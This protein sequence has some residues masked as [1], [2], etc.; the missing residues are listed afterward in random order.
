MIEDSIN[1]K[2]GNDQSGPDAKKAK[3]GPLNR[4]PVSGIKE[5]D[6]GI[7]EFIYQH[8]DKRITG[9]L[10]Q[11]YTDFQVN[12]IDP[13]G[14]VL[15][16]QDLGFKPKEEVKVKEK[17]PEVEKPDDSQ[18][19]FQ[20][21]DENK[22]K[23]VELI[24][25]EDTEKLVAML[26]SHNTMETTMCFPDKAKRSQIH[27]LIRAAFQGRFETATSNDDKIRIGINSFRRTKRSKKLPKIDHN[28]GSRKAFLR[29]NLYKENKETMEVAGI[30]SRILG[31][32]VKRI[33]Y[34]GTKDR[35]GIT[36]QRASLENIP[37][38]RAN[39]LNK[40]LRGCRMG[41]FEYS[42]TP[43]NLA[44]LTGNQFII[45]IR[46][47]KPIDPSQTLEEA[48][49]P[50][51]DSLKDVGFINYYGMQRFGT[52]SVSTHLIGKQILNG[53]W[54]NAA[55]L[56]LS[57]QKVV[58][59]SSR[60]ARKIWSQTK[61]AHLALKRMPRKC[62]A[63]YSILSRLD[64][65]E[66]NEDG[67]YSSG[68]YFNAIMGIAR[69]LRIMYAHAYQ[70]YIWNCVV[71]K[72]IRLWG[73]KAVVGDLILVDKKVEDSNGL[74][75]VKRRNITVA[76]T[77]TEEDIKSKKYTIYDVVLPTPGYDV[78]YPNN[79][80]L[81]NCY[82]ELMKKDG[83]DPFNMSRR[84]REFSL[85]GSYRNIVARTTN[86]NYTVRTYNSYTDELVRTDL[87]ILQLKEKAKQAGKDISVDRIL[88][89]DPNGSLKAIVLEMELPLS[90]YATMA[91]RELVADDKRVL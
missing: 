16:L 61:D 7:S 55:E 25:K 82:V 1:R 23:L 59:P 45:T 64:R 14:K 76:K 35:R 70:S 29:F 22:A 6:V 27:Q 62:N 43:V 80:K 74:E 75:D 12:E 57:E 79:E 71:S 18:P 3:K 28:L 51:F 50:I 88:P 15:H 11:R 32:Q 19:K 65:A 63:E 24:G 87:E 4:P 84:V 9:V 89:G 42:D 78:V 86:L 73:L 47:A 81:K 41:G 58:N 56:I 2:R 20:I 66:K 8:P 36:V 34:A 49:K 13:N 37:I 60:E 90:T 46:D 72:R 31:I 53:E 83:L 30:L 67:E 85:A 21:S 44:N 5:E 91:L 54:K 10:K 77:L 33:R 69:N 40:V 26:G 52:F 48:I 39:S 38:E 17:K 68:A